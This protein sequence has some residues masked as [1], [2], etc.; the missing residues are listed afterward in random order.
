ML[1]PVSVEPIE[2]GYAALLRDDAEP[3][4]TVRITHTDLDTLR[5]LTFLAT[6]LRKVGSLAQDLDRYDRINGL[7][8]NL[9]PL[10]PLV[11]EIPY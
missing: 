3:A 7:F 2:R 10:T 8:E 11:D 6:C 9:G 5:H 4:V 1:Q